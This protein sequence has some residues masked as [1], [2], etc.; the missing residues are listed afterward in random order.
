VQ[1]GANYRITTDKN[2]AVVIANER[3]PKNGGGSF[4]QYTLSLE[5]SHGVPAQLRFLFE[6]HLARL[7][8]AWGAD[9]EQWTGR[10]VHIKGIQVKRNNGTFWEVELQPVIQ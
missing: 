5:D 8:K 7:A 6:R 3:Q 2:I 4:T 1:D 10:L 9:P